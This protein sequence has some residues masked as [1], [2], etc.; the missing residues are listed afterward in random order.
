MKF[1]SKQHMDWYFKDYKA[2]EQGKEVKLT[3]CL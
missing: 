3:N 2:I 1:L